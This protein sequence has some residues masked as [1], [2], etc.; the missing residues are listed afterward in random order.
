MKNAKDDKS[1]L[2]DRLNRNQL[3]G[4]WFIWELANNY[5]PTQL[6]KVGQYYYGY[7]NNYQERAKFHQ[8]TWN[9]VSI[10]A[11]ITYNRFK[12]VPKPKCTVCIGGSNGIT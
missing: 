12:I 9:S 1:I 5:G 10:L 4:L 7:V 11:E 3:D 8:W 2:L 6:R